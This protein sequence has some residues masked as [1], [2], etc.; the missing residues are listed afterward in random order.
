MGGEGVKRLKLIVDRKQ[1]KNV[2]NLTE[3]CHKIFYPFVIKKLI[4]VKLFGKNR[5]SVVV[6]DVYTM[7][8]WLLT[9]LTPCQ[10]RQ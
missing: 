2:E 8:A 5:V 3:Q 6:D 1:Q 10:H 7:S 9:T 4:F